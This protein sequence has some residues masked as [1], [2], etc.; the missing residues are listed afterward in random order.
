MT[1]EFDVGG[2]TLS[3]GGG[4]KGDEKGFGIGLSKDLAIGGGVIEGEDLGTR[5]GCAESKQ[6]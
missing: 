4:I 1:D 3:V 6:V 2:G 5:E